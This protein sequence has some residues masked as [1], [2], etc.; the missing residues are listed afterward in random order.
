MQYMN[1]KWKDIYIYRN[2][3]L[4]ELLNAYNCQITHIK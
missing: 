1:Y 4:Y 2:K 3:K